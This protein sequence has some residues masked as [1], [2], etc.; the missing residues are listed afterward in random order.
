MLELIIKKENN[1][2]KIALIKDGKLAE[3]YEDDEKINQN[4]ENIYVGTI[5]DVLKGMQSA[6]I[7]VGTEKNAFIHLKDILPKVNEKEKKQEKQE[8]NI[9][10]KD[11][12]KENDKLLVQVKK[13][14]D[15]QKGA[16]VSTHISLPSRYIVLMPNTTIITISKKIKEEKEKQRLLNIVKNNLLKNTGAII[17]T[18]CEGK[19]ENE[20]IQ[21]IK[22]ITNIWNKIQKK[23]NEGNIK[24]P[25]LIYKSPDIAEKI[26]IDLFSKELTKVIVNDKEEYERLISIKK[27]NDCFKS[28]E[29]T[30]K[31]KEDILDC[32]DIKKQIEKIQD[33][34][35]W[36]KCGGFITIDKTEALTAIDVNTGKYIGKNNLEDTI[37][38][39]NEEATYEIVKQVKLRDIG[40]IIIVD[41]ID[42][43]NTK[44]KEKIENLLKEELKEDRAKTQ[45][46]GFTKLELME[47]TRKH[48]CSHS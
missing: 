44:D 19:S 1:V 28:I 16:R 30:L 9:D 31:E 35:I 47:F 33:R 45:V 39:V 38:K 43:N 12:V 7:D 24:S 18:A 8:V 25:A 40:G 46:E 23:Y 11:V 29:I 13:G 5:K 37:Y 36:L 4:E 34:K 27:E 26:I 20:L 42:M 21:D 3:Y 14:S 32:Y 17:R 15:V 2:K 48:I 6:F 41:Y 22:Y 10:I